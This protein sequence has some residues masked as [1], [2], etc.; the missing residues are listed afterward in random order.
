MAIRLPA[1]V[2]NTL[3]IPIRGMPFPLLGGPNRGRLWSI[4][5]LGRGILYGGYERNRFT[6]LQ[7]LV[8]EG[9][10]VWDIGAHR[11]YATLIAAR[12]AG[13]DGS[14]AAFEP[15]TV[16]RWYLERHASWNRLGNVRIF[17][18]A[19]GSADG[20]STIGGGGSSISLRIGE[21]T[22]PVRLRSVDSLVAGG[23]PPP[24]LAKID[25]EGWEDEVL[26]GGRSVLDP[27]LLALISIHSARAY[28][29]C[30]AILGRAGLR[31]YISRELQ[32]NLE[33]S[34]R[35]WHSDPDLIA[36]G[37]DRPVPHETLQRFGFAMREG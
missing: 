16:N 12:E 14:V 3:A 37:S 31:L 19:L 25:V 18:C 6:L 28:S 5:A 22:E 23:L 35:P 20:E 26:K 33:E 1:K 36:V 21:G 30:A 13:P 32:E 17:P 2:R 7:E 15:A 8:A 4:A 9:D 29:E 34:R 27:H 11:G 24:T 10:R